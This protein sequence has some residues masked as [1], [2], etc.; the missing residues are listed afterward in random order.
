MTAPPKKRSR[1]FHSLC[2]TEK[3]ERDLDALLHEAFPSLRTIREHYWKRYDGGKT[4]YPKRPGEPLE[5]VSGLPAV[6]DGGIRSVNVWNEPD[7]WAP[8]WYPSRSQLPLDHP[9]P[10][11]D[12]APIRYFIG[13]EPRQKLRYHAAGYK[14]NGIATG[15]LV[16]N[17][18]RHPVPPV[19]VLEGAFLVAQYADGDTETIRFLDKVWRIV[20]KFATNKLVRV[21]PYTNHFLR[22]P[23]KGV[24]T[25]AGPDAIDWCRLSPHHLLGSNYRPADEYHPDLLEE[26][27]E[28]EEWRARWRKG[29]PGVSFPLAPDR[30]AENAASRK[31]DKSKT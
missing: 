20:K 22:P 1:A 3:D 7:G 13:N 24:W 17:F 16:E 31:Q 27:D 21:N 30:K 25:W 11:S 23:E 15:W 5:Y 12:D 8:E 10:E 6:R 19:I 14:M 2:L 29:W 26:L 28:D 18:N 9:D 4:V